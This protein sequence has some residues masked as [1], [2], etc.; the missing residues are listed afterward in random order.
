MYPYAIDVIEGLIRAASRN[1]QIII[2]T[3]SAALVD[4]FEPEDIVVVDR[5]GRES[6]FHRL[7]AEALHEWLEEYTLSELWDRNVLEG[8]PF[9]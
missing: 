7:D 9:K 2:A 5:E 1:I 6:N 8:R 3:Q 4:Y